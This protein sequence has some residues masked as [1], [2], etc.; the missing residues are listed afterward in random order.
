[1]GL[2][3]RAT[4]LSLLLWWFLPLG[5]PAPLFVP[6]IPPPPPLPLC[7]CSPATRTACASSSTTGGSAQPRRSCCWPPAWVTP[8][9]SRRWL[10]RAWTPTCRTPKALP[11]SCAPRRAATWTP[12]PPSLPRRRPW[13]WLPSTRGAMTRLFTW[14]ASGRPSRRRSRQLRRCWEGRGG[15]SRGWRCGG[16]SRPCGG[17]GNAREER[18]GQRRGARGVTRLGAL[19]GG[20]CSPGCRRAHRRGANARAGPAVR[21]RPPTLLSVRS[22]WSWASAAA[23]QCRRLNSLATALHHPPSLVGSSHMRQQ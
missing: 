23:V 5:R 20:G 3:T 6:L 2:P 7:F 19:L 11:P 17:G 10:A 21:G 14:G 4:R 22:V 8:L 13:T 1:M 16:A 12:S 15:T 9:P 18:S